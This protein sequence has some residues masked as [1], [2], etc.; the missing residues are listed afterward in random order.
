MS[1]RFC[2]P[3]VTLGASGHPHGCRTERSPGG[4][5]GVSL[6]AIWDSA[7][8]L[9]ADAAIAPLTEVDECG[10]CGRESPRTWTEPSPR[11]P[12]LGR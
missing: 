5:L 1:V 3:V 7:G 12:E 10:L 4:R 9:D 8:L 6:S 2:S 11:S